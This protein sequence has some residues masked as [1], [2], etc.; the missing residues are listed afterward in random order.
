MKNWTSL[1][2]LLGSWTP[3][4]PSD[5]LARRLFDSGAPCVDTQTSRSSEVRA[6]VSF[7]EWAGPVL[8]VA[9]AIVLICACF[10]NRLSLAPPSNGLAGVAGLVLRSAYN[11][12][13]TQAALWLTGSRTSEMLPALAS[14][15][16]DGVEASNAMQAAIL[17]A[18]FQWTESGRNLSKNLCDKVTFATTNSDHC[19]P[20]IHSFPSLQTNRILL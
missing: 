20:G 1:E 14:V 17:P 4:P 19:P 15:V 8:A 11:S 5:D 7:P 9:V 2:T 18:Q 6:L 3:R 10:S 16:L 13:A 12:N